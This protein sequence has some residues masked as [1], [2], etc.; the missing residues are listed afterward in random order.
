MAGMR[1]EVKLKLH[2]KPI[3]KKTVD[4]EGLQRRNMDSTPTSLT[5]ACLGVGLWGVK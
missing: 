1:Y 3:F 5:W 2:V 4:G